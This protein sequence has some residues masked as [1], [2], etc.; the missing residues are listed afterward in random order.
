MTTKKV[1][2]G[3]AGNPVAH[4]LSP[5]IHHGFA[6]SLGNEVNY[7]RLCFPLDGFKVGA[8]KFFAVGGLGLNVTVP[9]KR[10]AC[11]YASRLDPVA[12]AAG[13]VNT[14]AMQHGEV[15]GYNTD[16]IG[17][18]R[19]LQVRHGVVLSQTSVLILG[20]GG[21]CQGIIR[22]LLDAGVRKISIANRTRSKAEYLADRFRLPLGSVD[23]AGGSAV[24]PQRKSVED[25]EA[26]DDVVDIEVFEL[27]QL[28]AL[29]LD[30]DLIINSTAMGLDQNASKALHSLPSNLPTGRIC[31]DLSYGSQAQFA[32]W[33]QGHGA[34][35]VFDGLG[36]LVE[37][38]AESYSIWMGEHPSTQPVYQQLRRQLT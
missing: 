7:Q 1:S 17:L 6:R 28:A 4:S 38:A 15:V 31:Y 32:R 26:T 21:A 3:V 30:A 18:V 8:S 22:P 37:Q 13:A 9:F 23:S 19:D 2:L 36:M 20:A 12:A 5:D 34:K 14:L 16:G 29:V 10:E 27:T 33:A 25:L 11:D 35:R 24:I